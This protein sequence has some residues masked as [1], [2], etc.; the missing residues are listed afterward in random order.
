MMDEDCQ[1][2]DRYLDTCLNCG[3]VIGLVCIA[4]GDVYVPEY[5]IDGEC[6]CDDR[7]SSLHFQDVE[8]Y[9]A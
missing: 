5:L 8:A 6:V 1:D 3:G 9:E 2:H 7:K 4:C